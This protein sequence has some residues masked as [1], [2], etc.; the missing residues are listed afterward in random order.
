MITLFTLLSDEFVSQPMASPGGSSTSSRDGSPSRDI[1]PLAKNL[2]PPIVIKK[3]P[4]GY[5]FHI[6]TI[7]VYQGNSDVYTLQHVVTVSQIHEISK[8][9]LTIKVLYVYLF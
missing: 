2:K 7:R 5:G 6:Q 9:K 3:G 1:S 4:R 8:C